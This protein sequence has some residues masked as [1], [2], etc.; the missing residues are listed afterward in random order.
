MR[1]RPEDGELRGNPIKTGPF[2]PVEWPHAR[3]PVRGAPPP[4]TGGIPLSE[5]IQTEERREV[6]RST[7]LCEALP[8]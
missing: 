2:A 5:N 4:Y 6:L 1:H 8:G 7:V 3:A